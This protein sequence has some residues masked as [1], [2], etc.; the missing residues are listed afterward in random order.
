[1]LAELILAPEV[2]SDLDDAYAWYQEQRPGLGEEFLGCV[3][4]VLQ[5]L[6]RTPNIHQCVHL[7]FRRA[8]VRRF[9][10][11]VF[12][13]A[14][15]RTVTVHAVFHTSRSPEALQRRLAEHD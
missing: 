1:M 12:F 4:A 9:P 13:E 15:V 7:E 5:S 2:E 6:R 8:L 11:A 10:Y 14:G 3:E